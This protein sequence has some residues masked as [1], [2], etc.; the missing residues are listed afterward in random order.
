MVSAA[1]SASAVEPTAIISRS[2]VFMP[3]AATEITNSH[4][5]T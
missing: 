2:E 1:M 3:S 5:D 4:L